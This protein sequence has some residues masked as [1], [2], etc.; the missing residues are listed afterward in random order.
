MLR[1]R[2]TLLF[3]FSLTT[4]LSA[5]ALAEDPV[6]LVVEGQTATGLPAGQIV[7]S[8]ASPSANQDGGWAFNFNTTDGTN[9]IGTIWGN[10]TDGPGNLIRTEGTFPPY[11]QNTYES[12]WGF[13]SGGVS[14][15]SPSCTN[16]DDGTTGL[17]GVWLDDTPI[18]VE[19]DVFP[20]LPGYWRSFGS[21]PGVTEDGIPYFVGGITDTQGG[22]TD[23]RGLF[24]GLDAAPVFLGGDSLPGLPAPLTSSASPGFDY[25][26]SAFG[27]HYICEVN[28]DT[29][30]TS[31]NQAM[32]FDGSGLMIDGQLVQEGSPV[33][34]SAGGLPGENWASFDY[35][36]VTEDGT[37]MITGDT[38]GDTAADEFVLING[39]IVMREGD[40]IDG[41]T[42]SGSIESGFMN[43]DGDYA[44]V[45]D[46]DLPTG[47]NVEAMIFNR[48]V[49]LMEGDYVD[50]DGDGLPN[51][52]S[53]LD[54][55]TGMA[56]LVVADRK[57]DNSVTAY[58]TADVSMPDTPPAQARA[59]QILPPDEAAGRD[60]PFE[61]KSTLEVVVEIG[62]GLTFSAAVPAMLS[63]FLCDPQADGVH[64]S[65]R[66]FG[67]LEDSSF[68]LRA[69]NGHRTW[70]VPFVSV[71]G[72][73]FTAIDTAAEGDQVTYTLMIAD[74]D[75]I[76]T[77]TGEQSVRPEVPTPNLVLQGAY[78]NPFNPETKISFRVG[79]S[80]HVELSVYDMSGRLVGVL[81]NQVFTAGDHQVSWN[82]RDLNGARVPSGTYVAR[83]VSDLDVQTSKLMLVK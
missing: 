45:W 46:V 77:V 16:I 72:G 7:D 58:F 41:Y 1:I 14:S 17:D 83:V 63:E 82:G 28:M 65:W 40:S 57:A 38:S 6:A 11:E 60:E 51:S 31:N 23:I 18:A 49:V 34:A 81:A 30:S 32:V 42:L 15:Y 48:Q 20:Y 43:D 47:E 33:P 10:A 12:F 52:D 55:F 29:G 80:Q 64:I 13:G 4:L 19:E 36:G 44:V 62:Y 70:E 79:A 35:V 66:I 68:I 50:T 5:G 59:G 21:R 26:F 53:F 39:M 2:T 25:R 27:T 22:S 73:L 61:I 24:F 8:I 69:D 9:T 3:V 76:E 75:G 54:N 78:P 67:D 56:A 37:Y 74:P 71:A